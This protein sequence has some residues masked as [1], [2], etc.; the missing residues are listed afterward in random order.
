MAKA[1]PEY[2]ASRGESNPDVV[3]IGAGAA[4]LAAARSLADA[5]VRVQVV[6][7]RSR[8]GGRAWTRRTAAGAAWDAGAAYV[9][10]AQRNPWLEIAAGLG[11]ETP[12]HRGWGGGVS[13]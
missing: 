12:R 5:R 6:E 13:F 4:G 10:F 9:H 2:P 1:Q 3:V 7:A 8:P 11:V